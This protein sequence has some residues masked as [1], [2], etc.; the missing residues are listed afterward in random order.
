VM[1]NMADD[2][3]D[4]DLVDLVGG[5][6]NSADQHGRRAGDMDGL[7]PIE[8]V[9]FLR[10]YRSVR[11]WRFFPL[12]DGCRERCS[13]RFGEARSRPVPGVGHGF[14]TSGNLGGVALVC[15]VV[16][17]WSLRAVVERAHL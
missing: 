12:R 10:G 15:A 14:A 2:P 3:A 5:S 9:R 13:R 7:A 16:R 6:G 4:G 8:N 17:T 1:S 11:S